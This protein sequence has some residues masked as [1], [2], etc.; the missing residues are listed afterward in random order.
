MG[1]CGDY[2]LG[3]QWLI[4]NNR[5]LVILSVSILRMQHLGKQNPNVGDASLAN[6]TFDK[7][8]EEKVRD[9]SAQVQV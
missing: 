9:W 8:E 6:A 1:L 4:L 7:D 2:L 5:L 3:H